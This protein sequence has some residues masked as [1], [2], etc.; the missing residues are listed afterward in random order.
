MGVRGT[1]LEHAEDLA[2][3]G[4]SEITVGLSGDGHKYDLAPLREVIQWRDRY[5]QV[6]H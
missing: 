2:R 3:A 1:T 6:N 5:N 4:V